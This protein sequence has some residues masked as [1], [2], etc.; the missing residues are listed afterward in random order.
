LLNPGKTDQIDGLRKSS[1]ARK[2]TWI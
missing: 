2:A 1:N